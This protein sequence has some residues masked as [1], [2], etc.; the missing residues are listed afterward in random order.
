[1]TIFVDKIRKWP[2]KP[3][4]GLAVRYF[5]NGK[6]SCHM[7]TDGGETELIEFAYNKLGLRPSW[8]QIGDLVHFDLTPSKRALAVTHGAIERE[9]TADDFQRVT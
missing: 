5:G 7:W 1:M 4:P 9:L 3:A 2:M 6:P 8:I